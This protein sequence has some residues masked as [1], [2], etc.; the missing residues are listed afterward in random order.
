MSA[1]A[2]PPVRL[3]EFARIARYWKPLARGFPGALGLADDAA[4]FPVPSDQHLVVTTDALVAGVH[5]LHDD[6]PADVAAKLL[7]TNLSDL[8]AMGA[9]PLAFTLV[10]AL[11]QTLEESWLADFA[12]GLAQ[13]QARFA[14][15]LIGGD[16]V[17]TSGPVTLSVTALGL[18]PLGQALL[19]GTAR[20]GD[21]VFVSGTI[22]DAVL[23]LQVAQGRLR[24]ADD[25][26]LLNRFR[27]PEPR[28]GVGRGLLRL[29]SA[30]IDVS[31][32]L[33]ADLGH[34]ARES[35][36]CLS[37]EAARVPLSTAARNQ[38]RAG[39]TTLAALLTGGDDYELAFTAPATARPALAALAG[40]CGVPIT[41]IG[42][43]EEAGDAPGRVIVHDEAGQPLVFPTGGGW[44]HFA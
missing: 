12:E 18:A 23:G 33:I 28:L 35:R 9:T 16:S 21:R 34:I 43:V 6:P 31:D 17:S 40:R 24:C 4:V 14:I 37:L 19:R 2:V 22:G 38:L 26:M 29:A 7:R 42:M 1:A 32:G 20:P 44:R 30:A 41:E 3:D 8:A 11:P 36:V 10:T 27:R 15:A 13:E 25:G 39:E 5:F